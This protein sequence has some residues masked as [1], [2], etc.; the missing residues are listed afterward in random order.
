MSYES[1]KK[2]IYPQESVKTI[3]EYAINDDNK[4]LY[5]MGR[6]PISNPKIEKRAY[7]KL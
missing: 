1:S 3:N 2:I 5:R 7:P 4:D 6:Q